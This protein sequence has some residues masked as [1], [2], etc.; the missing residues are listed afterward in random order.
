MMVVAPA[1]R[2][3]APVAPVVLVLLVAGWAVAWVV[4]QV[5]GRRAVAVAWVVET[6]MVAQMVEAALVVMTLPL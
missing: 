6:V 2:E 5:A 1:V 4:G 3:A